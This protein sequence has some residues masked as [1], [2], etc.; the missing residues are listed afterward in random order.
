M[1]RLRFAA[2]VFIDFHTPFGPEGA[3]TRRRR[4]ELMMSD[5]ELFMLLAAISAGPEIVPPSTFEPAL[6]E[7]LLAA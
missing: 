3:D 7:R 2:T 4:G 5:P 1:R 6:R